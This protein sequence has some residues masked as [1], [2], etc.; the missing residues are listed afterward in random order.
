MKMKIKGQ[1]ICFKAVPKKE[2]KVVEVEM[3]FDICKDFNT[4]RGNM[5]DISDEDIEA[6]NLDVSKFVEYYQ[7]KHGSSLKEAVSVYIC[8]KTYCEG[9]K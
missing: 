2:Q 6:L 1:E 4:T 3:D 9:N 8:L 5:P 7:E